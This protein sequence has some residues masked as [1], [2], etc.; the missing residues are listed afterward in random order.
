MLRVISVGHKSS[1]VGC[2]KDSQDAGCPNCVLPAGKVMYKGSDG[3]GERK[4]G[5][6]HLSIWTT[7]VVVNKDTT[8]ACA[9]GGKVEHQYCSELVIIRLVTSQ[10]SNL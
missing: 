9:K 1:R 2:Q 4:E 7:T 8:P 3:S 6:D 10:K 5:W